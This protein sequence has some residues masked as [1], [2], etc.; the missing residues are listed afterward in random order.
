MP[1]DFHAA[2]H[3]GVDPIQGDHRHRAKHDGKRGY[4]FRIEAQ[5]PAE[6]T[7]KRDRDDRQNGALP[8]AE[9]NGETKEGTASGPIAGRFGARDEGG[10]RIVE[11]ENANLA[12]E[13]SGG[14]CDRE[15]SEGSRAEQP[16]HQECEN[17]S[18][19]RGEE[20]DKV[21]P[22]SALQFRVNDRQAR[23]ARDPLA[24]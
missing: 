13:I 6:K 3:S 15:N 8:H 5:V 10:D 22:R 11:A 16:G 12:H 19:I 9:Q 2:R 24:E 7:D 23:L 20:R 1:H 21:R 18:E 14:P 4:H 17:A